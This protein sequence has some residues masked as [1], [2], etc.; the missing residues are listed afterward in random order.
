[1]IQFKVRM[2]VAGKLV[3]KEVE[4]SSEAHVRD[5]ESAKGHIV[6]EIRKTAMRRRNKAQGKFELPLFLQELTTLLNAG[7]VLVEALEALRDKSDARHFRRHVVDSILAA[8]YGGEPFSRALQRHPKIF[9]ALLVAT[10]ASSE[11]NGQMPMVLRRYQQYEARIEQIRKRVVSALIYP[12]VVVGVGACVLFFMAFFVVPRFAAVF[13][14]MSTLP[15]SARAMLW[16]SHL[17]NEHGGLV[18]AAMA[19][20]LCGVVFVVRMPMFKRKA[21]GLVWNTP[22]VRDICALFV[23]TRFYRTIGLLIS[24]GT[25]VI[26]ALELS[27]GILPAR[28]QPRLEASVGALRS[29]RLV[30]E[31]LKEN[32]L[33]TSVAERLLRAGEQSGELGGM[34]EHVAQFHDAELDRAVELL[35][36]VIEPLLML[37]VGATVGAVLIMLYMPIFSLA[38]SI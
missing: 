5:S 6:L 13:E 26:E 35:S 37:V 32:A 7:L 38:D 10:V 12:L 36:K 17:L 30:S 34:C 14:T 9:P 4:G 29:G 1:M 18:L 16:W 20:T 8:M 3:H 23:L 19:A 25:P 21:A 11:G 24:G 22:W 27:G 15:S 31:V 28:F 33:T 2:I